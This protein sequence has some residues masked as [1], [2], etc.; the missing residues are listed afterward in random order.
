MSRRDAEHYVA[1]IDEYEV[2]EIDSV[3]LA[4]RKSNLWLDAW[5]DLLRWPGMKN[6]RLIHPKTTR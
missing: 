1:E 4:K 2:V 5:R 3:K 6:G